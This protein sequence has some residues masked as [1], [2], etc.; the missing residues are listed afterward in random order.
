[1]PSDKP[2]DDPLL[3]TREA[4]D[5]LRVKTQ[6]LAQWRCTRRYELPTVIFGRRVFYPLSGLRKFVKEH[7]IK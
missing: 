5:F 3:T 7:S 1:M 2:K 6:T 4:A